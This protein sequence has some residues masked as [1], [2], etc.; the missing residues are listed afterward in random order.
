MRC[1]RMDSK[2]KYS[3]FNAQ[4]VDIEYHGSS[5]VTQNC[6]EALQ[7]TLQFGDELVQALILSF[8]QEHGFYLK[9]SY[10][11]PVVI[12]PGFT[13]GYNGEGPRGF[14]Y[15]LALL[16][17]SEVS[18]DEVMLPEEMFKRLETGALLFGDIEFIE[19]SRPVRPKRYHDFILKQHWKSKQ[20]GSLWSEF[21]PVIPLGLVEPRLIKLARHFSNDPSDVVFKAFRLLEDTVRRRIDTDEHGKKVFSTAFHGDAS[22]LYWPNKEMSEQV[23]RANLF[24]GAYLA[25]RNPKAH[26]EMQEDLNDLI[27]QFL[28]INQL[29][30]MENEAI[31]RPVEVDQV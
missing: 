10:D 21:K 4:S 22:P 6:I 7:R 28:V 15:C 27:R 16:E 14:S 17:T 8:G 18:V 9:D 5:G 19:K 13:T 30:F 11:H 25:F 23:G 29:F 2:I 3:S 26:K 12:L 20:E 31:D 1:C 24:I